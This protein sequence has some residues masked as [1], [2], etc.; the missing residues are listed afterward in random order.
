VA[1]L[2]CGAAIDEVNTIRKHISGISGGRLAAAVAAAGARSLTTLVVSD[3]IGDR[4]ESIGSGPTVPD[5]TTFDHCAAVMSAYPQVR[6]TCLLSLS[7]PPS[8][9]MLTLA[10]SRGRQ[11]LPHRCST[12]HLPPPPLLHTL[13][14]AV[15][16]H[17][18]AAHPDTETPK[19][20]AAP[21]HA[22]GGHVVS[23]LGAADPWATVEV[24]SSNGVAL[25]A[26]A[27]E[28]RA[29]G[30]GVAVLTTHMCG[31]AKEVGRMLAGIAVDV[32]TGNPAVTLPPPPCLVLAG[33]ETTVTLT[34]APIGSV[35]GRNQECA[36][37]AAIAMASSHAGADLAARREVDAIVT[38]FATDGGD[39]P[40]D[41]AGAVVSVPWLWA[42]S[43]RH[44]D[45]DGSR[46]SMPITAT[47]AAAAGAHAVAAH[48]SY[49][50]M[51]AARECG[52]WSMGADGDRA[53]AGTDGGRI[54]WGPTGGNV[55]D[56]ALIAVAPVGWN[57]R[58]PA[59]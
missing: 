41:S 12:L 2:S 37:A 40:T 50:W 22:T 16:A 20:V 13:P 21:G 19:A 42:A 53:A 45:G 25:T 17:L 49:G 58:S 54:M 56:V 6:A 15:V 35:G 55:M 1:L 30:L 39:G 10:G 3:V 18:H 57:P 52:T 59:L 24:V 33:G 48:D 43:S 28:A 14:P 7:L 5:P 29:M 23:D 46:T 32:A 38:C 44:H 9:Q 11:L 36:L 27:R 51:A 31:E 8:Q 34:D 4:L 26:I 47:A